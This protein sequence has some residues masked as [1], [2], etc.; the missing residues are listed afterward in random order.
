MD[1]KRN[2]EKICWGRIKR[3]RFM[4]A[5]SELRQYFRDFGSSVVHCSSVEH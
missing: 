4:V 2:E 1:R 5:Y 3:V